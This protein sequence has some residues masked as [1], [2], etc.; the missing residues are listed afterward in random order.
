VNVEALVAGE[1]AEA[2]PEECDQG[3]EGAGVRGGGDDR[4]V[5]VGPRAVLGGGGG[6]AEVDRDRVGGGGGHVGVHED[7]VGG[8][9]TVTSTS[10]VPRL[11]VKVCGLVVAAQSAAYLRTTDGGVDLQAGAGDDQPGGGVEQDRE[12]GGAGQAVAGGDRGAATELDP[13]LRGGARG[14]DGRGLGERLVGVD[15]AV[16]DE[17]RGVLE[18]GGRVGVTARVGAPEALTV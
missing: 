7:V 10:L 11:W 13:R 18:L 1:A 3:V 16:G 14:G 15:G 17:H 5:G 2:E 12:G 8:N 9:R 4:G 6:A